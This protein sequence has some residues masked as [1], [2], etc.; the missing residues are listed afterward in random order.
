MS[1]FEDKDDQIKHQKEV[2][3]FLFVCVCLLGLVLIAVV[4]KFI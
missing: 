2:I 3:Q 4:L 1:K